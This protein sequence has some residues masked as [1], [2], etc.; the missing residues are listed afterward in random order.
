M[1][2]NHAPGRQTSI[3]I[4][5]IFDFRN[6]S[7]FFYKKRKTGWLNSQNPFN[8]LSMSSE[9]TIDRGLGHGKLKVI[10]S[11]CRLLAGSDRFL[12]V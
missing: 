10:V 12:G 5:K 6:V 1:L 4:M 8:S 3:E 7:L 11:R 2:R 9:N